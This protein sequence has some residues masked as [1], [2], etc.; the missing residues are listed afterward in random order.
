MISI[1][2]VNHNGGDVLPRCLRQLATQKE[3]FHDIVLAENAST[4]DSVGQAERLA[5]ELELSPFTVLRLGGNLGFGTANNRAMEAARGDHLLLLNSDAWPQS[6]CLRY[7]A[8]A[9]D[10]DPRLALAAPRLVY[11]DGTPQFHW[12]PTTSV[13]GEA[14]Q[15][16]RNRF[17][18]RSWVHALRFPGK[19]W[20]SAACILLRRHA[21]ES[22]GGFDEEFF[23]Y[24]EDVDLSLRLRQAGWDLRTVPNAR[25]VHLKGGSQGDVTDPSGSLEYRRGQLRYY[26]KHRPSWEI[27]YLRR[28]LRSKFQR[29]DDPDRRSEFLAL[30]R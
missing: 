22:I 15:K 20:Y 24:F 23:L 10:D 3:D 2:I 18:S 9:L 28:R 29:I 16:L 14:L 5:D 4:D 21:F 30:L 25:S 6:D 11:D 8:A 1:L 17:E 13:F 7:L 26:E 12:A 27:Q 19:G